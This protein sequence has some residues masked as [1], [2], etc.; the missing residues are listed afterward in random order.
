MS[1][2]LAAVEDTEG[3]GY[4]DKTGKAEGLSPEGFR[5]ALIKV[6]RIVCGALEIVVANHVATDTPT[7]LEGDGLLPAFAAQHVFAGRDAEALVPAVFIVEQDEAR[8]LDVVT[9]RSGGSG[10]WTADRHS[11]YARATWLY[12]QWLRR[13]A[14]SHSIPVVDCRPWE[15]LADRIVSAVQ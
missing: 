9:A 10:T 12:G 2:G 11:R 15:T 6:A 8:V 4:V 7:I 1:E 14:I 13:E 3:F 5:D